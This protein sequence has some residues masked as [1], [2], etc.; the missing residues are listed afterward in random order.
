M[1]IEYLPMIALHPAT[2]IP[3]SCLSPLNTGVKEPGMGSKVWQT[4]YFNNVDLLGEAV[5]KGFDRAPQLSLRD[6]A[7]RPGVHP[8]NFAVR[9]TAR[10]TAPETGNYAFVLS[11]DNG[12]R[13]FVNGRLVAEK[14][15]EISGNAE[16][17]VI[18]LEA[19]KG[20]EIRVE[21]CHEKG[22]A[23]FSFGWRLPSQR[24]GELEKM[25]A[26]AK[27]ADAVLVFT[28]TMH[29]QG[30]A[31]E[32]EGLDRP[33]L[34]LPDGHDATIAALLGAN[35]RTVVIN[36]SGAPVEMPWIEKAKALVQYWYSGQEGGNALA[37]ILFG[38]VNPSGKL[39]CTFPVKLEDTPAAA[40]GNYHPAYVNYGEGVFV[41]YRWYDAKNIQP[42]F[43]FGHGLSYT[44]FQFGEATASAPKMSADS[45]LII[46]LPVTNTGHCAGAEVVQLY[47]HEVAPELPRPPQ[48][49]KGFSKLLLKPGETKTAL[50]VVSLHDL[51]Y[52]DT[53]TH[54]W[55]A[56]P[57]KFE[58]RLGASSRD[59]RAKVEFTLR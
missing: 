53:K 48:E 20:Y 31:M 47:I 17:G 42:L 23:D 22:N 10:V 41:G 26:K 59:L 58:A 43:P 56:N 1:K 8:N 54:A 39:P 33:D 28:G 19:G 25:L 38:E 4:E 44:T 16:A 36:L 2:P 11:S 45:P 13:V 57:G 29:D 24:A 6:T 50:F 40:L 27:T 30:R 7:A 34:K 18:D 5:V 3:E 49:L 35:P 32:S 21:Y 12:A 51:S 9:W 55:K 52:W 46:S 15:D 14:G 37:K